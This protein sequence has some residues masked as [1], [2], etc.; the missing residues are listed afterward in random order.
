MEDKEIIKLFFDRSE[1]AV[2]ETERKYGKLC[3][4]ISHGILRNSEDAE[5][6]VNDTWMTAWNTIPPK[7][8]CFL[9]AFLAK[10]TRNLSISLLR[11]NHSQ[12]R[13]SSETSLCIDELEECIPDSG[14]SRIEEILESRDFLDRFLETLDT[15]Q[16]VI[17]MRRYWFAYS[18]KQIAEEMN[19]STASVKMSVSRTRD[20]LKKYMESEAQVHEER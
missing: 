16:R 18:F 6:C 7:E 14:N 9:G 2:S 3:R 1:N 11:K 8:P 13:Y 12:K 10:I 15:K 19:M 17:F 4:T 20:K 5:E